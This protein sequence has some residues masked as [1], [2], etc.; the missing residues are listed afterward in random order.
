MWRSDSGNQ[1]V[2]V[3]RGKSSMIHFGS[4]NFWSSWGEQKGTLRPVSICVAQSCGDVCWY[5]AAPYS[6][7]ALF[8]AV[9]FQ[10][11][12]VQCTYITFFGTYFC[13][14]NPGT[15]SV[16]DLEAFWKPDALWFVGLAELQERF[17]VLLWSPG[18]SVNGPVA[19]VLKQTGSATASLWLKEG[20]VP[21]SSWNIFSVMVCLPLPY[22]LHLWN[23]SLLS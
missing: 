13:T 21:N 10:A 14:R 4:N 23:D 11:E 3:N 15:K 19:W 17:A 6:P 20:S 12:R 16:T 1:V 2:E 5:A 22:H 7:E 9:G 18:S 8:Q